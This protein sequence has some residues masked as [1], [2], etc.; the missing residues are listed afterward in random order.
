VD[1]LLIEEGAMVKKGEVILR[2][3]NRQLYQTILN[4]EAALAEKKII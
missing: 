1:K 3:E 4:S 2:L